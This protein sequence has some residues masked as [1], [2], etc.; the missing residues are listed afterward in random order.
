MSAPPATAGTGRSDGLYEQGRQWK[1]VRYGAGCAQEVGEELERLGAS[2]PFLLSTASVERA[3]L[4]ERVQ[5]RLGDRTP[6]MARCPAH[7]PEPTAAAT[8]AE[9]DAARADAIVALGGGS[10]I[11][12]AKAVALLLAERFTPFAAL[13]AEGVGD[14]GALPIVALPTTLSGAEFTGVVATT[15][16]AGVKHL[17]LDSRLAPRSVLL[18]PDLTGPTPVGLWRSTGVKTMSDAVEQIAYGA[19]PVTDAL[20]ERAIELFAANLHAGPDCVAARLRC[21][22]AAWM[23]LF[24]LH[25]G[26]GSVG[27]GAA[28]RHQVAVTFG[29]N[30]GEVTC[31]LLP[32]VVRFNAPA[33]APGG[34]AVARA[35]GLAAQGD[36]EVAWETVADCLEELVA[37]LGLPS[38]LSQIVEG[39]A[40]LEPLAERVF[41]EGAAQRSPR[42]VDSAEEIVTL[43]DKAW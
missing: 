7:V 37:R 22:Q 24:G 9:I 16:V 21:Q 41:S 34:R 3:G 38:R 32:H 43:L 33:A 20:C 42:P 30:H 11:D 10:V 19:G 39:N 4:L 29:A 15:D 8:A 2:R 25:D 6:A 31:V 12:T 5:N 1:R 35:L 18:D 40:E 36:E 26:G 28:L 27:L 14:T 17:L 13:R 23:A